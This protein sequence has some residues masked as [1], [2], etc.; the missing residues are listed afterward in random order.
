T[1]LFRSFTR[2]PTE[3][4]YLRPSSTMLLIARVPTRSS[5]DG[6]SAVTS[7]PSSAKATDVTPLPQPTSSR[8]RGE[9]LNSRASTAVSRNSSLSRYALR[10]AAKSLWRYDARRVSRRLGSPWK[11]WTIS[12]QVHPCFGTRR[13]KRAG[14][15]PTIVHG[16]TSRVTTEWAPTIAPRPMVT[17]LR[18]AAP[19]LIQAA[20]SIRTG[21]LSTLLQSLYAPILPDSTPHF[22]SYASLWRMAGSSECA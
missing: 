4:A 18:M 12:S 11:A 5:E 20:S 22:Q 10:A 6:S 1:T 9:A 8:V 7:K 2:F 3:G 15:P 14:L 21:L 16:A 19:K 13:M 17:P